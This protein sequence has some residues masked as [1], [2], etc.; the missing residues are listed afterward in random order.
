MSNAIKT[1][2]TLC[3]NIG[4]GSDSGVGDHSTIV[5]GASAQEI[6]NQIEADDEFGADGYSQRIYPESDAEFLLAGEVAKIL[7]QQISVDNR[8]MPEDSALSPEQ[9]EVILFARA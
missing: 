1:P 7:G 5:S 3:L 2:E 8:E 4:W 6:A 9:I